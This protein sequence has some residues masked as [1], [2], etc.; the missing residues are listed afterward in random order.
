MEA[1][2]WKIFTGI[3]A[4]LLLIIGYFLRMVHKDVKDNTRETGKNKGRIEQL[5]IGWEK[6]VENFEDRLRQ[7]RELR[8]LEL[9]NQQQST[10]KSIEVLTKGVNELSENVKMLVSNQINKQ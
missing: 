8:T 1:I 7:E 4:G 6:D 10:Q 2:Y 9:K 5:Q 3:L